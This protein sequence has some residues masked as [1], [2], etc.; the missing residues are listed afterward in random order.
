MNRIPAIY[1]VV[2]SALADYAE[3]TTQQ[4]FAKMG[5]NSGNMAFVA[6]VEKILAGVAGSVD[7]GNPRAIETL[8]ADLLVIPC[9]NQ[10]GP[11]CDMSGE[12]SNLE[13]A[14]LPVVALG[15]GAQSPN[16]RQHAE[17]PV[18]TQKWV[19]IMSDL[20]VSEAPNIGV[21]G[22]YTYH[23]LA[24]FKLH[25]KAIPLGCPSHFISS[26][27]ELGKQ[28]AVKAERIWQGRADRIAVLAGNREWPHLK[29]VDAA[30]VGLVE[31]RKG[32][33]VVQDPLEMFMLA[34]REQ[35]LLGQSAIDGL[36]AHFFP[37][38]STHAVDLF[39]QDHARLYYSAQQWMDDYRNFDFVV[40]P[41]IHGVMLALQMGIPGLCIAH[42]SRTQELCEMMR[43][44]WVAPNEIGSSLTRRD[45]ATLF[46]FD[47]DEFDR[48]RIELAKRHVDFISSNLLAPSEQLRSLAGIHIKPNQP[49]A[50]GC[51][52]Y[53]NG[54]SFLSGWVHKEGYPSPWSIS[55]KRRGK[56]LGQMDANVHRTDLPNCNNGNVGFALQCL[57]E[58][59]ET[60]LLSGAVKVYAYAPEYGELELPIW[61]QLRSRLQQP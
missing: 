9:A 15:L 55:V 60:E 10:F 25:H 41:R 43:V 47:P 12:A 53:F 33:F 14:G 13:N 35:H 59:Y 58:I 61:D 2:R 42:D 32:A 52:D 3:L 11:H 28:I 23:Q 38:K 39:L 40:G 46:R 57:D 18:G 26:N 27:P 45:L 19:S 8:G 50:Q 22:M 48:N 51:V 5:G 54:T 34:R 21:R 20:A 49:V 37:G 24:R 16:L 31:P 7:W 30:L 56:I 17:P 29:K 44:P 36:L 6:G 1:Y 4:I